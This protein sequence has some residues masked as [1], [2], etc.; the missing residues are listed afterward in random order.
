M[1]AGSP[2]FINSFSGYSNN[3]LLSGTL[4]SFSDKTINK[5]DGIFF[6][7]IYR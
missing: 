7:E 4:V 1:R 5:K 6:H 3:V 2:R